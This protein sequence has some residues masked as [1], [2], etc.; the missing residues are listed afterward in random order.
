MFQIKFVRRSILYGFSYLWLASQ[1]TYHKL[2]SRSLDNFSSQNVFSEY[3]AKYLTDIGG[4][5]K[6]LSLFYSSIIHYF[7]IFI[8][9]F[10]LISL[11]LLNNDASQILLTVW[12]LVKYEELSFKMLYYSPILLRFTSIIVF[13]AFSFSHKYPDW[14]LFDRYKIFSINYATQFKI[15]IAIILIF[16]SGGAC[17]FAEN[18]MLCGILR[19]TN[20]HYFIR[21]SHDPTSLI[22]NFPI[23]LEL[24]LSVIMIYYYAMFNTP[25]IFIVYSTIC[26]SLHLRELRC[27]IH[28]SN[29]KIVETH[30]IDDDLRDLPISRK[31]TLENRFTNLISP[32]STILSP[33]FSTN[34]SFKTSDSSFREEEKVNENTIASDA[35]IRQPSYSTK[36]Y[37]LKEEYSD[38]KNKNKPQKTIDNEDETCFCIRNL[39]QLELHLTRVML[40]VWDLNRCNPIFVYGQCLLGVTKFIEYSF[41]LTVVETNSSIFITV[42]FLLLAHCLPQ[43]CIYLTGTWL[44]RECKRL[45][46][47]IE[48][49]TF[50]S[51]YRFGPFSTQTFNQISYPESSGRTTSCVNK[52]M[53]L[54]SQL[55]LNC[56]GLL[57]LTSQSLGKFIIYIVTVIFI[58]VQYGKCDDEL[59]FEFF[60]FCLY[61]LLK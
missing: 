33:S 44:E 22:P 27:Q 15:A 26:I 55:K 21:S 5:N 2:L 53:L 28:T 36:L 37:D 45:R 47:E 4:S 42:L 59:E 31:S 18:R 24:P 61:V 3:P 17:D 60:M 41:V 10:H 29:K 32:S 19:D 8:G 14:S 35:K 52:I 51:K 25:L 7:S 30:F 39:H 11:F 34:F 46:N 49:I 43:L 20:R 40:F 1:P 54:L 13:L 16:F 23:Y 12:G 38:E 48:K 57:S 58:V 6:S 9:V 50:D 56:D